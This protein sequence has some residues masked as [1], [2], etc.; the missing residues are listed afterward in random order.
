MPSAVPPCLNRLYILAKLSISYLRNLCDVR[1]N[2]TRLDDRWL[3]ITI[4]DIRLGQR[5]RNRRGQGRQSFLRRAFFEANSVIVSFDNS[6]R[7]PQ[8]A[9]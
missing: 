4:R 9:S 6:P 3:Q 5:E 2:S 7:I 1:H 8:V